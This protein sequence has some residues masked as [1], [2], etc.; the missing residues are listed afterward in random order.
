MRSMQGLS[1]RQW[2]L[3]Q[4]KAL[5]AAERQCR[6]TQY[7]SAAVNSTGGEP[8][9]I[10]RFGSPVPALELTTLVQTKTAF[11]SL[12][13]NISDGRQHVSLVPLGDGEPG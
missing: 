11:A 5:G 6:A 12:T 1:R 3:S 10:P 4:S 7:V 9:G 2:T 8:D 13:V